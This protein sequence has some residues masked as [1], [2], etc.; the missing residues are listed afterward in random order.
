MAIEDFA[1]V[2]GV[3]LVLL[4]I[5]LTFACNLTSGKR[6]RTRVVAMVSVFLAVAVLNIAAM[7]AVAKITDSER[8]EWKLQDP[9][10][11]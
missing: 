8:R 4:L 9:G 3:S 2:N 1:L 5:G 7:Y 6:R 11:E 10:E